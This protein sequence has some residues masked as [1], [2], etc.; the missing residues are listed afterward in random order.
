MKSTNSVKRN[1]DVVVVSDVHLGTYGCHATELCLYLKSIQ[2]K[3]LVLNGDIVDGWQ[4]SRK[5]WPVAHHEVLLQI[6]RMISNGTM[7]YYIT[8]NH[9]EMLRRFS[10]Y[11]LTNFHLVDK[12]VLKLDGKKAWIF[13]GDVFD[14]SVHTSKW[15]AK[16]AGKSYDYLILFNRAVNW[17]LE[18]F[19]KEKVSI[20]KKIKA[21][22][23]KAV[24]YINDFEMI[25]AQHAIDQNYDYVVCGHIHQPQKRVIQIEDKKVVYLNS[26]DWVENLSSLEYTNGEWTIFQYE[27]ELIKLL[28][29]AQPTTIPVEFEVNTEM[30]VELVTC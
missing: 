14:L 27:S 19:G 17:V 12:L 4:F 22:V 16:F 7:V 9:D 3:I 26:G 28:E 13:H 30:F 6:M 29:Q 20:S 1:I 18:K 21:G 8:G 2:P 15:L 5:Y 10:D 11:H 25:A 24:S 23:K